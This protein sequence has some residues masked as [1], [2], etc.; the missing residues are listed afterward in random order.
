MDEYLDKSYLNF[1][2]AWDNVVIVLSLIFLGAAAAV[3]LYY[4]FGIIGIKDPKKKYEYINSNEIKLFWYAMLAVCI[5]G[6]L[7]LNTTFNET[8]KHE[9]TWFFVRLFVTA[10]FTTIFALIFNSLIKVYYPTQVE[11]KLNKLRHKPRLNPNNGNEMVLL[12]ED[13]EDKYLSEQ[14]I[15]EEAKHAVDYD[16][17][18]DEDTGFTRIEK[19]DGSLLA[20]ECPSCGYRTLRVEKEEVIQSPTIDR[21]GELLNY[22]NCS[23]CGHKERKTIVTKKLVAKTVETD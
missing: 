21:E 17:W 16:V 14:E 3:T 20:I 22:Y 5:A 13:K 6:G 12:S 8:V 4:I 7:F 15:E 11:K 2:A 9:I 19:Y 10:S 1:L 18:L 23:Y